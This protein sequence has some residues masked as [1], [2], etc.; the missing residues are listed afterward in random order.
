MKGRERE[1]ERER[2]R[3]RHA[4]KDRLTVIYTKTLANTQEQD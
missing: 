2:E 1:R 3:L 4:P